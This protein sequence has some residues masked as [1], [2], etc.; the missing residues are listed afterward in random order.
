MQTEMCVCV[1]VRARA[2]VSACVRVRARVS[3]C[4]CFMTLNY[5]DA[6]YNLIFG[7]ALTY[8]IKRQL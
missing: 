1:C 8:E 6:M 7:C 3:V 4:V 5:Q 2:R